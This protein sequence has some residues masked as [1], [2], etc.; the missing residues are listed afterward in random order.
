MNSD[1]RLLYHQRQ[2]LMEGRGAKKRNKKELDRL[3]DLI[4]K[5]KYKIKYPDKYKKE[6]EANL[7]SEIQEAMK[8]QEESRILRDEYIANR[9]FFNTNKEQI[10]ESIINVT[11]RMYNQIED[12]DLIPL[13]NSR[14]KLISSRFKK[15]LV[16]L[17]EKIIGTVRIN[18]NNSHG[19]STLDNMFYKKWFLNTIGYISEYMRGRFDFIHK[20]NGHLGDYTIV[21]PVIIPGR[22]VSD[23]HTIEYKT[24]W[25]GDVV[26]SIYP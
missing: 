15:K 17:E 22:A 19:I 12:T 26:F 4:D 2:R 25:T 20:S 7:R 13:N 8:S 3:K 1:L 10:V 18:I 21:V 23:K 11:M 16:G 9:H 24:D 5:I 14:S 6:L